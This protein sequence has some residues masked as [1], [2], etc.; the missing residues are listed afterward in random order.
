[1]L[2][3]FENGIWGYLTDAQQALGP[4]GNGNDP[5]LGNQVVPDSAPP[6]QEFD[7]FKQISVP[8]GNSVL[9][10]GFFTSESGA[11]TIGPPPQVLPSGDRYLRV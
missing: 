3:H 7:L 1:M 10:C 2:V 6:T 4:Y 9:A 8:H 11:P 5:G